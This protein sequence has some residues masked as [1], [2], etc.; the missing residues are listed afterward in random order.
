[1]SGNFLIC[2]KGVK[3][4]FEAQEGTWDFFETSSGKGPQL[5]L[6]G[7]SIDFHQLRQQTFG[8]SLVRMGTSGTHSWGHQQRPVS[9]RVVRGHS[10]LL[11]SHY[12]G[13]G[14]HLELRP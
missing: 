8:Q 3:D 12:W 5:A 10:G 6:R 1:M 2:L 13:R 7:E 4:P 11:C 14:S 9:M